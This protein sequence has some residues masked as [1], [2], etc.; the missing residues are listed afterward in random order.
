MSA[1]SPPA[2]QPRPNTGA[3][4][5]G[6]H[7]RRIVAA[8]IAALAVLA[9]LIL[10]AQ[11][12]QAASIG[13]SFRNSSTGYI[14]AMIAESDGRQ[15]YCLDMLA[16][17]PTGQYTSGPTTVTSLTSYNGNQLSAT[18]L[19]RLNYVLSKWGDSSSPRITAAVQ[20][21]VWAVADAGNYDA[22]VGRFLSRIPAGDYD[23]VIANLAT[24]QTEA[25]ANASANP[26]GVSDVGYV[27]SGFFTPRVRRYLR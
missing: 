1:I 26:S 25:A 12:A 9:S 27:D 13:P 16:A 15:V 17:D 2:Q 5:R 8:L 22:N 23:A 18:S 19:A 10:P 14:G 21:Y 24:M 4:D 11:S 7:P 6:G 3:A 20:L